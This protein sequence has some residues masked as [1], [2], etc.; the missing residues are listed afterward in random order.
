MG[1]IACNYAL[2]DQLATE[3]APARPGSRARLSLGES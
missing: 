2:L 3:G 1:M